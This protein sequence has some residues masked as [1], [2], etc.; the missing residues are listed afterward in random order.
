MAESPALALLEEATALCRQG[1]PAEGIDVVRKVLALDPAEARAH[2]LLGMALSQL[3]RDAEA[4][5]SLDQAIACQPNFADAYGAR[6]DVLL[7]LGRRADAVESYRQAL[8]LNPRSIAD[9]CNQGAALLSLGRPQEAL[10]SLDQPIALEPGFAEAYFNRGNA[11]TQLGLH[12]Q[13]L[14]AFDRALAIVPNHADALNNRGN[15]LHELK[16][17]QEALETL[18]RALLIKADHVPALVTR[19]AVLVALARL[20]EALT[21]CDR[22]L[23]VAP[24]YFDALVK[25]GQILIELERF[26][27]AVVALDQA[28]AIQPDDTEAKW[29][30][31]LLCLGLGRFPEGWE[32]YEH[33]WTAATGIRPRPYPQ[34]RWNGG[35]VDGTLLVWG[36]QGLGD[37]IL[38]AS[39]MPEVASRATSVVLEAEPRLAPLFARSFPQVKVIPCRPDSYRG[40]V[41]AQVPMGSLGRYLRTSWDSFPHRDRGYLAADPALS[42]RLRERLASDGR[43]AIGLVWLSRSAATGK[44]KSAQLSELA[45][46]L[47]TPGCRFVDLQYGDTSSE[48]RAIEQD[49]GVKVEHMD[50]VD[51]TNNIDALAALIAAC[52]IVVSVSS[53][54][55]HLAGALGKP[56]WVLVPYGHG[57]LWFWFH[58]GE[59]S[60]WYPRVRVKRQQ[61]AQRWSDLADDIRTEI[62]GFIGARTLNPET[63]HA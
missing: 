1:R 54:T 57:R 19:A 16:R 7:N 43:I 51:N 32:L 34:P 63:P 41:D 22:A 42:G 21:D 3:G 18:D 29:N 31:S 8:I 46:L 37:E 35:H 2:R 49:L 39:M 12:E 61:R 45:S 26:Q 14:E 30:K 13:A 47:R 33:R 55:A 28:L 5:A 52:D 38:Y 60:P 25:R 53:G 4:L 40:R 17:D 10:A 48:R 50:D 15:T 36:E 23:A 20:G 56:T 27:D 58:E 11:L 9:W 59:R 44:S 6:A 62:S 24:G